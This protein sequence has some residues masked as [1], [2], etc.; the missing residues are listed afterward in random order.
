MMAFGLPVIT[1]DGNGLADMF[2][3]GVN[4]VVAPIGNVEDVDS[5]VE[6]TI[7]AIERAL[8]LSDEEKQDY[9]QKGMELVR[10]KYSTKRMRELYY[11]LLSNI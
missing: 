4:A 11:K 2:T 7:I 1:T 9:I 3:D 8:R 5:F 10:I 6:N